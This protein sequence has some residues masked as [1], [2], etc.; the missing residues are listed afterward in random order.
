[1]KRFFLPTTALAAIAVL[2]LG[3]H[4]AEAH[5]TAGGGAFAGLLHPLLGLDHLLMLLAVGTPVIAWQ[6]TRAADVTGYAL[7]LG[8]MAGSAWMSRFSR[9]R[10]GIGAVMFVASDLLIFAEMGP[11]A[12]SRFIGVAIWALYF[13]GQFLITLGVTQGLGERRKSFY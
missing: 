4:P 9:Y 3:A 11:L 13:A 6:L 1:M 10:T 8:L 2:A 5:G 7:L 12:G